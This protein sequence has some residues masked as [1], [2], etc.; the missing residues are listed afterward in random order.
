MEGNSLAA[1]APLV[2]QALV[3]KDSFESQAAA[4]LY[5]RPKPLFARWHAEAFDAY[6]EHCLYWDEEAELYRLCCDRR[7]EAG[8]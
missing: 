1:G 2:E 7:D 3:R 8:V 6:V 4:R 5:W